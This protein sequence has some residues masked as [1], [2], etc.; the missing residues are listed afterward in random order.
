MQ[1]WVCLNGEL[2][3]AE[4]ARVSVFDSGFMQGVGL[5]ETMR[6][7]AGIVFRLEQHLDRLAQSARTLGWAVVPDADALRNDVERVA[8]ALPGED[9][10]IRLTVTTG[11]LRAAEREYP[12]LTVVAS[13]TPGGKYPP[14]FYQEGIV[15]MVSPWRQNR[16]DPTAGHKTTSYFARL[17]SLREAHAREASEAVWLTEDEYVAEGAISSI[18]AVRGGE[19]CT[20][21]LNTPILPG[22]TRAAVIEI[23][24]VVELPVQE[25]PMTL[26]Q[27][28]SA[29]EVFLT[30]S[31][32]EIMPVVKIDGEEIGAGRPGGVTVQL[33]EAYSS[34]VALECGHE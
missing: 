7:Y 1:E 6:S 5:F 18:F 25:A 4:Q 3:P 2:M 20:P 27:L 14:A 12:E 21:P 26:E 13:A 30:N 10:R 19:L 11:S 23:A 31:M 17:A 22:I 8:G 9:A 29:D 15:V 33:A 34:L 24:G 16:H 32:M 28:Q